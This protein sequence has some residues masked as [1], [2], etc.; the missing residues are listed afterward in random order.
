MAKDPATKSKLCT[1]DDLKR[2]DLKRVSINEVDVSI[3]SDKDIDGDIQEKEVYIPSLSARR[4]T[5]SR[6]MSQEVFNHLMLPGST[7]ILYSA[8]PTPSR[9][10][11][12]RS[13]SSRRHSSDGLILPPHCLTDQPQ[14]IHRN[15]HGSPTNSSHHHR[16][17]DYK[18]ERDRDSYM[19]QQSSVSERCSNSLASSR[20]SSTSL[21]QRSSSQRRKI[22]TTSHSQGNGKIPWCACW[23]NGCL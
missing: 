6:K 12:S 20:E 15:Y 13:V 10:H 2:K 23:G 8:S 17:R 11:R 19:T 16:D 22:S 9:R 3:N 5:L 1:N 21:S 7:S 4:Q 18:K 14:Q